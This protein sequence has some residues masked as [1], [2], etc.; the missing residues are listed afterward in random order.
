[1]RQ[2][3]LPSAAVAHPSAGDELVETDK[4]VDEFE[5]DADDGPGLLHLESTN[6]YGGDDVP[7]EDHAPHSVIRRDRRRM[8]SPPDSVHLSGTDS[9]HGR[10][11]NRVENISVDARSS[12]SVLSDRSAGTDCHRDGPFLPDELQKLLPDEV[13]DRSED[14]LRE[15]MTAEVLKA[16]R[17]QEDRD[18]S[19]SSVHSSSSLFSS[20]TSSTM[21]RTEHHSSSGSLGGGEKPDVPSTKA[22]TQKSEIEKSIGN[23]DGRT[24]RVHKNY[25]FS[26]SLPQFQ[27]CSTN[28]TSRRA[29]EGLV[30]IN[31]NNNNNQ[32]STLSGRS[33]ALSN[34]GGSGTSLAD[35][36]ARSCISAASAEVKTSPHF[37]QTKSEASGIGSGD[38]NVPC[39]R[40]TLRA[41]ST[42]LAN[43]GPRLTVY[44]QPT[45]AAMCHSDNGVADADDD[46]GH[47]KEPTETT[48]V[49]NNKSKWAS[50]AAAALYA[51]S[52]VL[53]M[54][55]FAA[56]FG[57][58]G[59]YYF[60]DMITKRLLAG[61]G[62]R[63]SNSFSSKVRRRLLLTIK[64]AQK[65]IGDTSEILYGIYS[66]I[67]GLQ[68]DDDAERRDSRALEGTGEPPQLDKE[69]M[70]KRRR[71]NKFIRETLLNQFSAQRP[72]GPT[73][74]ELVFPLKIHCCTWNVDQVAPPSYRNPY[75][76][77]WILGAELGRK[78]NRYYKLYEEAAAN[79]CNADCS[80]DDSDV[81]GDH[82]AD[83]ST[84]TFTRDPVSHTKIYREPQRQQE[85]SAP[86]ST[87]SVSLSDLLSELPDVLV[88]S[89]QEVVMN[90]SA[91]VT[92]MTSSNTM[93]WADAI[94][95][96]LHYVSRDRV[97]YKKVKV[98]QL[99]GLVLLFVVREEHVPFISHVR[100]S[101]TRT[102]ALKLMGNKGSIALRASI[103]GKRFLF[104]SSHFYAH[105]RNEVKR[106][107]NYH[108]ALENVQFSLPYFVDDFC[109]TIYTFG[110]AALIKKKKKK[111]QEETLDDDNTG[112]SSAQ[113]IENT[114][115]SV[116][117]LAQAAGSEIPSPVSPVAPMGMSESTRSKA[118]Q[119][120]EGAIG[121]GQATANNVSRVVDAWRYFLRNGFEQPIS[122][123]RE[124][125]VLN[126]HDYV[127]FLGD[128]NS[129][130][131]YAE[132]QQPGQ[133]PVSI[134]AL[135]SSHSKRGTEE[136]CRV[137]DY[138]MCYDE[139]RQGMV[140]GEV[141]DGFQ[142]MFIDFPP[143]YKY[144][145]NSRRFDT[146]KKH[147]DP[148]WCDRVLFRVLTQ[149]TGSLKSDA[150]DAVTEDSVNYYYDMNELPTLRQNR[151]NGATRLSHS[152][153]ISG[154]MGVEYNGRP[155]CNTFRAALRRPSDEPDGDASV[156]S[157]EMLATCHAGEADDAA[158]PRFTLVK[159][160]LFPLEYASS[161]SLLM[162]DHRP[163]TAVAAVHGIKLKN[164]TLKSI[165][166]GLEQQ[167]S[168]EVALSE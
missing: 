11:S 83:D 95:S 31:R 154:D 138:L 75:F 29:E 21:Y 156:E 145:K 9:D 76:I 2:R 141:F 121:A 54:L 70:E 159:N 161:A 15:S 137:Y 124:S 93:R 110:R 46:G 120:D 119:T 20:S 6:I 101:V 157:D 91:L 165:L 102:G 10:R 160:R 97:Q 135:V 53:D 36:L 57:Y 4:A 92:E 126:F 166:V 128:L 23:D 130:L 37:S 67:D 139:L 111:R 113:S 1:M 99:V 27:D 30:G 108:A 96:S 55:I 109:D 13:I 132:S 147:R 90:A 39:G 17:R 62:A 77:E 136:M 22:S 143:T 33:Q 40:R 24:N 163:V 94:V 65:H 28:A 116:A 59:H 52:Y 58:S 122:F 8:P 19:F 151:Q 68:S 127:F 146:S 84:R 35:S 18:E 7:E 87:R 142:E 134:R 129:R 150:A 5:S 82:G 78:A 48:G 118:E 63:K 79:G 107:K 158:A 50:F 103:Y 81:D 149:E 16:R 49:W 80:N 25:R 14:F 74:D 155:V 51:V 43:G 34:A 86:T 44:T 167:N 140:S 89:L 98:I 152:G 117:Y 61:R 69:L 41:N 66:E 85:N 72:G 153:V 47:A 168:A 148:A 133:G 123:K 131:H 64:S 100:H 88:V 125:E 115:F 164:S 60:S 162:S 38:Y 32:K 45:T 144:D 114:S 26:N 106:M 71:A 56:T 3:S 112:N 42:R 105:Q 73:V 12:S 104:F